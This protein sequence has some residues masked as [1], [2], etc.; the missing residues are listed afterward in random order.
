MIDRIDHFARRARSL[1]ATGNSGSD[2]IAASVDEEGVWSA[3]VFHSCFHGEGRGPGGKA[4]VTKRGAS[5]RRSPD[6]APA[7]AGEAGAGAWR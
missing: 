5:S 3:A 2:R 4:F 7:F 6:R 1:E